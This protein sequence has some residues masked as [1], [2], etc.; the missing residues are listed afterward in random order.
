MIHSL[1]QIPA[2]RAETVLLSTVLHHEKDAAAVLE[3][4]ALGPSRRWIV[5]ENCLDEYFDSE[6][7]QF[8]DDFFNTTLNES[9]LFC[10][11]THR[12]PA[13]WS[14]M[15]SHYGEI[16]HQETREDVPGIFLP[17]TLFVLDRRDV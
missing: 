2:M 13:A 12:T 8:A 6:F 11:P 16:V 4:L 1:D 3:K 10:G 17:H 9:E 7:Q 14:S 5:I 15:L